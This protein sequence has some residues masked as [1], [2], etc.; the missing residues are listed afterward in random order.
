MTTWF[1]TSC[2]WF[3]WINH[4]SFPLVYGLFHIWYSPITHKTSIQLMLISFMWLYMFKCDVY[5]QVLTNQTQK[6]F[7]V[8]L[9]VFKVILYFRAF[10]FCSKCIFVFFFKKLFQR[11][12]CEKL[13]RASHEMFLREIK[14]SHFHT[15]SLTTASR[16]FRD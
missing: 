7:W 6:D 12:F 8:F 16:V 2:V 9:Y 3:D 10:S 1:C 13:T 5:A 15:K 4:W 14:K 11:S